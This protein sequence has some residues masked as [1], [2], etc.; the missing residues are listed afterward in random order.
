MAKM[1]RFARHTGCFP[2]ECCGRKT[3]ETRNDNLRLCEQCFELSG[4]ENEISDGHCTAEERRDEIVRLMGE[5]SAHGA[6]PLMWFP[7][8][9]DLVVRTAESQNLKAQSTPAHWCPWL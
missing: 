8:F 7:Q 3:R 1:N 2:C 4:I 5:L 9:A 6:N